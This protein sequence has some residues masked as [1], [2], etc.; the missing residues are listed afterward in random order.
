MLI[1]EQELHQIIKEETIY[2]YRDILF[3]KAQ[4]YSNLL[5]EASEKAST[6]IIDASNEV[7]SVFEDKTKS[8]DALMVALENQIGIR[9]DNWYDENGVMRADV[10]DKLVPIFNDVKGLT[11]ELKK[12]VGANIPTERKIAALATVGKY[13]SGA[14]FLTGFYKLIT[15]SSIDIVTA[16]ERITLPLSKIPMIGLPDVSFDMPLPQIATTVAG[17]PWLEAGVYIAAAGL[18]LAALSKLIKGGKVAVQMVRDAA[19]AGRFLGRVIT[20]AAKMGK[21]FLTGFVSVMG[22]IGNF[23]KSKLGGMGS[24]KDKAKDPKQLAMKE[25]KQLQEI[26]RHTS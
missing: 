11:G 10:K 19:A 14:T 8:A 21:T 20:G 2:A 16:M 24:N 15:G 6:E 23:I 1:T 3:E 7:A 5:L 13:A 4:K 17:L 25:I 18:G 9:R 12:S 26:L 22:R